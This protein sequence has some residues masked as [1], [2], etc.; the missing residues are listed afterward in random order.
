MQNDLENKEI[1]N[2][3]DLEEPG[4]DLIG[5]ELGSKLGMICETATQEL[6]QLLKD[7]GISALLRLS[8][9]ETKTQTKLL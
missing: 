1:L 8:L 2:I 3:T 4:V 7:Y 6:N 5:L 9:V